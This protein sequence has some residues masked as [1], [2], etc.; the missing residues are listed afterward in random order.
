[1]TLRTARTLYTSAR[2]LGVWQDFANRAASL[3]I[4]DEAVRKDLLQGIDSKIGPKSLFPPERRSSYRSPEAIDEA[5]QAAYGLLEKEGESAYKAGDLVAGEMYNP[6]VLH[7]VENGRFDSGEPVYRHYLKRK[8]EARDLMLT[9]QRLE[10]LHVIP[11]TMGTLEPRADVQVRFGHNTRGEF[12]SWV[13]PGTVMPAFAVATP[14]TIKV[15][16]F[17]V[18]KGFSGL[19]TVVVV[20]PDVPNVQDNSFQTQLQY[21]LHNVP[22]NYVANEIGPAQLLADPEVVFRPY[23][24]LVPEKNAPMQRGCLWVFRQKDRIDAS[25]EGEGNFDIREFV[26]R[27]G[28]DAVGAHVWRQGFDRSVNEVRRQ[29]GLPQGRV[30]SRVRGDRPYGESVN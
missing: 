25:G 24:P 5:F 9:M 4:S 21:G 10:Q 29:F 11:D 8:W 13:E 22:L 15:Q 28:L 1:M 23:T 17:E 14:P 30:F 19:Y 6:E 3:K 7:N 2:R 16:E 20:N 18:P 12:A 27:H 26:S